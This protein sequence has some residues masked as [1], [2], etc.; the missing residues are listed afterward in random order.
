[1]VKLRAEKIARMKVPDAEVVGPQSGDVLLLGWGCTYGASLTAAEQLRSE[2]G[3]SVSVCQIRYMNPLP[4]NL[5][6]ILKRFKKVLVP[7]LNLG[8]LLLLIRS[9]YLID[10]EGVNKVAGRPFQ[11]GE[12]VKIVREKLKVMK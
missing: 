10:A 7:E 8:Q 9:K 4:K 6:D 1:M 5:G 2:D 3:A 11:V 12:L